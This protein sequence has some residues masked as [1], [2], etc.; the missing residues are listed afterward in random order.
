MKTDTVFK[1]SY[2]DALDLLQKVR[3]GDC[4]PSEAQLCLAL[5]VSRTTVRKVLRALT[6]AGLISDPT[7]KR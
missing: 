5:D 1:R 2:N 4:L 6:G 3:P 7:G